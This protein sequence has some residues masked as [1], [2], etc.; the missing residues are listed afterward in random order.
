ME[1][2]VEKCKRCCSCKE[3]CPVGAVSEKDGVMVIDES[4]CL[5]C[6]CCAASCPSKA[7]VFA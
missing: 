2:V 4:I 1:I 3:V 7:I 6:G 5:G